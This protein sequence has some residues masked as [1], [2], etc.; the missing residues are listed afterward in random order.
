[1]NERI[2]IIFNMLLFNMLSLHRENVLIF[3]KRLL[4]LSQNKRYFSQ[5]KV[6]SALNEF[7]FLHLPSIG[8]VLDQWTEGC[9]HRYTGVVGI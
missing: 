3:S 1:M 5:L 4:E 6:K 7:K 2:D 9:P 8:R